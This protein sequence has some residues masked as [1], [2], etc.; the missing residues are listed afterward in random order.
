MKRVGFYGFAAVLALVAFLS[1]RIPTGEFLYVPRDMQSLQGKVKVEGGKAPDAKGG[2]FYVDVSVRRST[3][4]E[5]VLPFLEPDGATAI[6]ADD[7]LSPGSDFDEQHD[8][9]LREMA[10]SE[11]I[12]AAVAL[13]EAG[14]EVKS[15]PRGVLVDYV[16]DWSP[17]KGKIKTGDL[18]VE[19]GG[20]R[21]L[22][23]RALRE[24]VGNVRPGES[25]V[26]TFE[27]GEK[28]LE[29]TLRTIDSPRE[30]GRP[31]IGIIVAQAARIELPVEVTID[32]GDVGG[33]SAGLPFALEVLQRLGRDVDRG[34]RVAATG[35][36]E[37]DGSLAP[38]GGIKQKTTGV[39]RSGAEVFL[40]PVEN[41]AEARKYAKGMRVIGSHTFKE[42]LRALAALPKR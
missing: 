32:L 25:V 13:R 5:K 33:P 15:R 6:D 3:W 19:V 9:A 34:Y 7:Y 2:I 4:L 17:S 26:V 29:L 8:A 16:E 28:T 18:I 23:P 30:A 22:T 38:I 31:V 36:I 14:F 42:A 41:L 37:L 35:E 11:E 24:A 39:R 10:R 27:R 40:V 1:F 12:A 21:A 20:R